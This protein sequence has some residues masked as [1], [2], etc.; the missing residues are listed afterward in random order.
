MFSLIT[1]FSFIENHHH[2]RIIYS[3]PI[4]VWPL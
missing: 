1:N 2:H 4:T 3:A